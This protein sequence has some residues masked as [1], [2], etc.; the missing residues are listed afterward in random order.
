MNPT[1]FNLTAP[2]GTLP[3]GTHF[4]YNNWG[5]GIITANNGREHSA[6]IYMAGHKVATMSGLNPGED[7]TPT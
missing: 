6:D 2:I 4:T 3:T 7:V 1:L 5:D